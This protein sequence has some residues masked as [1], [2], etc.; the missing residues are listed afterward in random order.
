MTF[1]PWYVGICLVSSSP[2][3]LYYEYVCLYVSVHCIFRLVWNIIMYSAYSIQWSEVHMFRLHCAPPRHITY[4]QT[5]PWTTQFCIVSRRLC[6]YCIY[7]SHWLM[8]Y[9]LFINTPLNIIY[10]CVF[11]FCQRLKC[12]PIY[13]HCHKFNV[14]TNLVVISSIH[15]FVYLIL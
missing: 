15:V 4:T 8:Q 9:V 3:L 10:L 7:L 12:S 5:H 1:A 13:A 14:S 2:L 11:F 6:I